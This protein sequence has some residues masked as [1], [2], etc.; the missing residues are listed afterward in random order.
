MRLKLDCVFAEADSDGSV[1][2]EMKEGLE[3]LAE[4]LDGMEIGNVSFHA[5]PKAGGVDI[6]MEGDGLSPEVGPNYTGK[7]G[8]SVYQIGFRK[9]SGRKTANVLN[10]FLRRANSMLAKAGRGCRVLLV[11][12]VEA[13]DG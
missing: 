4:M 9:E 5:V 11:K 2:A 7:V 8:G 10:M 6:I 3:P 12:E 1:R 13:L